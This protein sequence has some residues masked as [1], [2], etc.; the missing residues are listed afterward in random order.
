MYIQTLRT[1]NA[2]AC[3]GFACLLAFMYSLFYTGTNNALQFG[4]FEYER[5]DLS[6]TLIFMCAAFFIYSRASL[7]ARDSYLNSSLIWCHA[8]LMVLGAGVALPTTYGLLAVA[9]DGFLVGFPFAIMLC[10]WGRTLSELSPASAAVHVLVSTFLAALLCLI[11]SAL[12][13]LNPLCWA[14]LSLLPIG[15]A[16]A[17]MLNS[18]EEPKDPT[19]QPRPFNVSD[20]LMDESE[21]SLTSALSRNMLWGTAIFGIAAGF[22]ETFGSEPGMQSSS[23]FPA[24]IFFLLCITLAIVQLLRFFDRQ[25]NGLPDAAMSKLNEAY[26]LCVLIMLMGY[27]FIYPLAG[28][29]VTGESVVLGGYL[30]L[31]CV[32]VILFIL[33]SR[34]YQVDAGAWFSKGFLALYLGEFIGISLGNICEQASFVG[35]P[36]FALAA[37]AGLLTLYAYQ[38]L[39]TEADFVQLSRIVQSHDNFESLCSHI[40]NTYGLSKREAEILPYALKGRTSERIAHE[41]FI[42]KSTTDTHLKR[43][44]AKCNVHGRQELLDL[45]DKLTSGFN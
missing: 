5:I 19:A 31:S 30:G 21:R 23:A 16:L 32:F 12:A 7:K 9:L 38:F 41:L 6:V 15:S 37:L 26:R 17:F 8:I 35:N 13:L 45:G 11:T 2:K 10:A 33:L 4:N 36:P 29:E 40:S 42:S 27:L 25:Q 28:F 3:L 39:F 14:V 44:Y 18:A 24:S 1:L 43:I 34:I 22:M 20:L